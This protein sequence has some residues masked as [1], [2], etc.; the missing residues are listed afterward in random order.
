[1]SPN[2]AYL[3]NSEIIFIVNSLVEQALS[4]SKYNWHPEDAY[5]Q[6]DNAIKNGFA[7]L[8]SLATIRRPERPSTETTHDVQF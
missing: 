4:E 7:A 3:S 8:C 1:M 2:P 5:Y 6:V